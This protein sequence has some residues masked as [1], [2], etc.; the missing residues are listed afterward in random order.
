MFE[1]LFILTTVDTG[2]RVARFLVQEFLGGFEPRLGKPD[3]LPGTLL[4]TALTCGAWGYLVWTGSIAT[5][6]PMLGISNQLLACI[7]LC[8]ATTLTINRG[9]AKYAW[10]T[11]LPLCFVGV[12]TE[13]AGY[14]LIRDQF[15][16]KLI[17][18]GNSDKVFQGY[19]LSSLCV[20]AM[21]ALVV[22]FIDSL[23]KWLGSVP[24]RPLESVAR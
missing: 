7:A 19:L 18:S 16:P 10:V 13:V 3:W 2:T 4:S 21:V 15:V 6:W 11:L 8:A 24:A 23:R 1:A 14:Q 20:L 9:R 5:I 12:A 17:N 22:I